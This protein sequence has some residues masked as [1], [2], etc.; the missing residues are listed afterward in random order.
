MKK[1]ALFFIC[2]AL[3]S[4]AVFSSVSKVKAT[5]TVDQYCSNTDLS[6]YQVIHRNGTDYRQA[7]VPTQNRIN[8]IALKVGGNNISGTA[9]VRIFTLPTGTDSQILRSD[10]AFTNLNNTE[11]WYF[12]DFGDVTLTP[13]TTYYI[14]LMSSVDFLYWYWVAPA[15]CASTG[16][17]YY[18]GGQLTYKLDYATFGF[19]YTAPA[20][21]TTTGNSSS[22]TSSASSTVLTAPSAN[23]STSIAVPTDVVATYS[24]A[25]NGVNVVWTA[26]KTADIT[27]Y[28]IYRSTTSGKDYGKVGTVAKNVLQYA[29]GTIAKSTTY[30]YMVRAYK[31]TTE[32]V[33]SNEAKVEVSADKAVAPSVVNNVATATPTTSKFEFNIWTWIGLGLVLILLGLLIFLHYKA[34]RK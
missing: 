22:N 12:N 25:N 11:I 29:D 21:G 20:T 13:G 16:M 1:F 27:G 8:N 31:T 18:N 19:T 4:V 32:S 7:F 9:T 30:F 2:F 24:V 34:K 17:A 26:S 23:V 3:V 10:R 5:S 15:N 28:N 6:S 14:S 33:N